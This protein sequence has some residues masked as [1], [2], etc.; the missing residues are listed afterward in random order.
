M[1]VPGGWD[2]CAVPTDPAPQIDANLVSRYAGLRKRAGGMSES[3]RGMRFNALL[4]DA[5]VRDGIDADAD[6]RGPHG[7]VDVAF[8]YDRTRWL[9]EAKWYTDPVTDEPLRHL[10]D[11][12]T[13][14]RPGT[15]AS[16]PHGPGS[17][18]ARCR[19]AERSRDVVLLDRTPPRRCRA[20]S[21]PGT[22]CRRSRR[23]A[24]PPGP[25][26]EW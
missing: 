7:E 9:L 19:R 13:E 10:R 25:A 14:R 12:L 6:Q 2:T 15:M 3:L 18:P 4:A 21:W 23:Y 1:T 11:L 8:C 24:S 17:P 22:G 20:A 16:S 5:L 26:A